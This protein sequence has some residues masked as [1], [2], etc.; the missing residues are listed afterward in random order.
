MSSFVARV[1][2]DMTKLLVH[3]ENVQVEDLNVSSL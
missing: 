1:R 3:T 2:I